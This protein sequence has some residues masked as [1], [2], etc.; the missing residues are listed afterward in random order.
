[1]CALAHMR[2]REMVIEF[3]QGGGQLPE[4]AYEISKEAG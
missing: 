4:W 3:M 1:M 2:R